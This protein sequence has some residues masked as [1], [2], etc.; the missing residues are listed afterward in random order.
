MSDTRY[1]MHYDAEG[2]ASQYD[3]PVWQTRR[4][5]TVLIDSEPRRRW[6]VPSILKTASVFALGALSLTALE[7]YAPVT[8]RPSTIV[9][10]YDARIASTVKSAE[11]NQQARFEAW[12]ADVKIASEQNAE[13]YRAAM[14]VMQDNY[15]AS[16]QL[17]NIYAQS[18]AQMQ[19]RF[20]EAKLQ[21]A[22]A[23]SSAETGIINMTKMVGL[24]LQALGEEKGDAVIAYSDAMARDVAD[25]MTKAAIEGARVDITGWNANLP[26]PQAV[27]ADIERFAPKPVPPPPIWGEQPAS[28]ESAD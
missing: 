16:Y 24:G 18:A 6:R 22:N 19:G 12:A 17:A 9:G 14:K 2:N 25:R 1:T 21:Q 23:Q 20:M 15:V 28:L 5:N 10:T 8:W 3:A 11:L 7:K 26:S 27:R 13:N 4:P